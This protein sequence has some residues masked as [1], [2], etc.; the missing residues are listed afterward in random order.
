MTFERAEDRVNA[1][2]ERARFEW[3][4]S[5]QD[6]IQLINLDF[7]PSDNEDED[8]LELEALTLP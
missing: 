1:E 6:L 2:Q 8:E 4:Q 3:N 5:R 7:S